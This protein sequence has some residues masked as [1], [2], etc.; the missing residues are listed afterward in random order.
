M[1][2]GSKVRTK[3]GRAETSPGEDAGAFD[4]GFKY[5]VVV[6]AVAEFF[7]VAL[8]LYHKLAR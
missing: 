4:R 1:S 8:L 7:A 3:D 2:R 6:Y 5:A